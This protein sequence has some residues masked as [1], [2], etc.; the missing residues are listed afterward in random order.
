M[1]GYP[2]S[3]PPLEDE[4][5]DISS[6]YSLASTAEDLVLEHG[7]RYPNYRYGSSPFP[8]GDRIAEENEFALYNL[9]F[10]LFK[11]RL[12]LAPVEQPKN[13]L[14][15][16]CGQAGL[17]AKNMA[18][19]FPDAQV[20]AMDLTLPRPESHPNLEFY[21]QS[22]NDE[23]ILDEVLQAHGKFDFIFGKSLFGSSQDFPL[24]YKRCF[25]YVCASFP[26]LYMSTLH[27][28]DKSFFEGIMARN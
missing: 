12:F 24:F 7:R 19:T 13:I 26:Y 27:D 23:W 1:S 17:W 15:V 10:A 9:L 2:G 18:D 11:G 6:A 3:S 4:E 28:I 16:R 22:L 5:L 25:E 21:L 20:T 8:R 14:D